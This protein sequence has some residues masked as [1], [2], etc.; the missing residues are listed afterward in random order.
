MRLPTGVL[1]RALKQLQGRE[2]E[3]LNNT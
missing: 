3:Q 1:A 2:L